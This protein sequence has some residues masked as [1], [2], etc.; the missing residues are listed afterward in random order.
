MSEIRLPRYRKTSWLV[1][2]PPE[3][4]DF[5]DRVN[6]ER[7]I[8][9]KDKRPRSYKRYGLAMTRSEKIFRELTD[10]DYIDDNNGRNNGY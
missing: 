3:L 2:M 4:K 6:R 8:K 10:A 7:L 5:L 9:G 1:K